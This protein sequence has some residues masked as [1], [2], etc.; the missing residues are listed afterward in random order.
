MTVRILHFIDTLGAGGAE[1]QL[2]YLLEGLDRTRYESHV[3]TT[4]DT[5]RH[6]EPTLQRLGIPIYS[7]HH[8]DLRLR[9]RVLAMQRYIQLMRSLEPDIV[10]GWLH[11]P[12]LIARV[13]RPFCPHHRLI[14][15]IRS[16]YN[17]HQRFSES[18]TSWL[19]DFRVVI[20]EN[21]NIHQPTIHTAQA[22]ISN[23]VKL[24]EYRE[25]T[26]PTTAEFTLLM[27]ARIDPRKD[28]TTLLKAL[29]LL[30]D[31]L[32]AA[33]Q[34]ILIGEVTDKDTQRLIDTMIRE[35]NLQSIV[36]QLPPTDNLDDLYRNA[37]AT[38]LP[39]ISEGFPNVILESFATCKPIIVSEAANRAGLVQHRIN[40]WVFQTGDHTALAQCIESAWQTPAETRTQMGAHGRAIAEQHS[41]LRM[42]EAY[43]QLYERAIKE[44]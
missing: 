2:I 11:Y 28:H 8:G 4:Y 9:N 6:Y 24:P 3:L 42:V 35:Y 29:K 27:V 12:N 21:N 22:I 7:L 43:A 30:K 19:S 26:P 14:T 44:Q 41:I 15:A 37:S 16:E 31:R 13:A 5:F 25:P 34:T 1:R 32:P 38:V 17:T 10:H 20:S 18:T 23:G 39:S 33:F 40:G 36:R